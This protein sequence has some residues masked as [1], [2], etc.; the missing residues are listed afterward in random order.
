M[1]MLVL[2]LKIQISNRQYLTIE[3]QAYKVLVAVVME[4]RSVCC[5]VCTTLNFCVDV[6]PLL[7]NGHNI[8]RM[9][10]NLI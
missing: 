1:H 5:N 2:H 8:V 6:N 7:H 4:H 9:P 10:K 3:R